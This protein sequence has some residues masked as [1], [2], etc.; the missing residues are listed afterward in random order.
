MEK[1]NILLTGASGLLGRVVWRH[2]SA[3]DA[4]HVVGTAFRRTNSALVPLNL[5]DPTSI[6]EVVQATRPEIIIHC[7]AERRP[8]V[9]ESQHDATLA[10]NAQATGTLAECA[11]PYDSKFIYISTD[12]V[13]EGTQP[14]YAEM[15]M[16]RPLNFYG[17]TKL[18]GEQ[19]VAAMLPT[20]HY[21]LRL[22]ILYGP[23]TRL[24][25]C[26]AMALAQALLAT[27]PVAL[28]HWAVRFPT[29]TDDVALVLEQMVA[30]IAR[31]G[32][33]AGVYHWQSDEA[34]TKYELTK[35]MEEILGVAT[36]HL[37]PVTTPS[38]EAPRPQNCQMVCAGLE[39]LGIGHRTPL[40]SVI[41]SLL[42][43]FMR[44]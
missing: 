4:F 8:D 17:Q 7:A 25:E 38:S 2:F 11:K 42:Q 43:P 16:P 13:F 37:V 5:L 15:A 36:D 33:A 26:P 28:D 27:D 9:S 3:L 39:K 21:I 24:D 1:I 12:Y 30:R 40:R 31:D 32:L 35:A 41:G 44:A 19:A 22:P 20:R 6:R 18:A 34:F 29:L 14:P 23:V 10:L